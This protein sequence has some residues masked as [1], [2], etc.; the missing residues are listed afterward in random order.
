MTLL[1]QHTV[2]PVELRMC[3][4]PET[5]TV[6]LTLRLLVSQYVNHFA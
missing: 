3:P 4:H 2:D 6:E 5:A 1:V